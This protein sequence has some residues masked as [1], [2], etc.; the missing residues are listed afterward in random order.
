MTH[1]IVPTSILTGMTTLDR[2]TLATFLA[3]FEDSRA[4][5]LIADKIGTFSDGAIRKYLLWRNGKASET[6]ERFSARVQETATKIEACK[7]S[8]D[9]LR[10][11]LWAHIRDSFGLDPR[12]AISPRDL[13][14]AAN[15][16]GAQV[17]LSIARNLEAEKC[18]SLS[19]L[20]ITYWKNFFSKIN[21]FSN[22]ELI[23][24]SFDDAVRHAVLS[25]L[26]AVHEDENTAPAQ[27]EE[28]L[29]ALKKGLASLDKH[30]LEEAGVESLTDDAIRKLLAAG[31]GLIGLMGAVELA[32]FGAYILAAQAS[33]IIPLVGGKTLISALFI[34]SHPLFVFPVLFAAG[35][36]GANALT[37][38]IRQAFSVSVSS[39][40]AI[41]GIES[42]SQNR[43][44][45]AIFFFN[46]ERL[47]S[48][49][50]DIG[51]LIKLPRADTYHELGTSLTSGISLPSEPTISSETRNYLE[52]AIDVGGEQGLIESFLFP[53]KAQK[54]DTKILSGMVLG[55]FLFDLSAIDPM[56]LEAAD[57]AHKANLGSSFEFAAFAEKIS[58]LP[59][60]SIRGHEANLMGYTAERVVASRL[61]ENGFVVSIPDSATQPGFDL[62]VDGKEFQVKC[63]EPEN[64]AILERHFEK[65]PDTPVIANEEVM[66]SITQLAPN[67]AGQVFFLEGYTYEF[68]NGLAQTSL[69]AGTELNDYELL[70]FIA[71]ISATR[72]V[73]G[74]WAGQQ[75]LEE[76]A[77]NVTIDSAAKGIMAVTG[78]FVGEGLG[79]LVFGPAGAYVFGG[80]IAVAA[81]MKGHWVSGQID[82]VLDPERDKSLG[83]A[84]TGLLRT[85]VKHLEDKLLGIESKM[86][87]L[88]EGEI[89]DAFRCRWQWELVFVQSK[90]NEA[91]RLL[92][93]KI[94]SGEGKAIAAL[95]LASQ[96]GI[97]PAWLQKE[98]AELLGLLK[99]PKDRLKKARER[100]AKIAEK[101]RSKAPNG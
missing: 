67:W 38:T 1:K 15:D 58:A 71:A 31:G 60:A 72:N 7:A 14:N 6:Q 30:I 9:S 84:A 5:T 91:N 11:C 42:K 27:R 19:K 96:C 39:L 12:I 44:N 24:L 61:T 28:I 57:F 32:G 36:L 97:H 70:P 64:I 22:D 63:I 68:A 33:A 101:L 95:E 37:K 66:D 90:I 100:L 2:S 45:A 98:Y 10:M 50:L 83:D 43:T 85:C 41:N 49:T 99:T 80:V 26:R 13:K 46:S 55:D 8:D 74:W 59:A 51:D 18:A 16:V 29:S 76:S 4:T 69:E 21:P 62:I 20:D 73:H 3:V 79:M 88:P 56:V 93:S 86:T 53:N 54:T 65:Y 89:A 52:A 82:T 94:Y 77:F 78:G 40:L 25:L 47:I 87:S 75:S 48:E 35:A 92:H 23:P 81:T 17:A 34:M